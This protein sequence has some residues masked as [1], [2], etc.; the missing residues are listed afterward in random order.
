MQKSS[1]LHT[2]N[3]I[4]LTIGEIV[5]ADYRTAK[6]FEAN[7][8]DFCCGGKVTFSVI[9][10][11][12][13]LDPV[14]IS[15]EIEAAKSTPVERY[16]DYASWPLSFLADYIVNT[17]HT[18]LKEN[19]EQISAYTRKIATVHGA[20]HPE[21]VEIATIF[22]KIAT[23]MAAHLR[24]EEEVFFPSIKRVEAS[25]KAGNV[26]LIQDRETIK[27]SLER[28]GSEH[29]EIGDAV[30]SISHLSKGYAI[31]ND[32]CNTFMITYQKLK[33]FEEDLHKHVHLENNILFQKAV[34]LWTLP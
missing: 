30:H 3:A 17:H 12:R 14:A 22:S 21:V 25:Q 26:P 23:D 10:R 32:V 2:K 16:R 13:G 4:D 18:Y 31:P 27:V 11:E 7:G 8:I 28:L 6:V 29:E 24:E 15:R 34:Q 5:A 9:C 33:E 1:L 20:H 19:L